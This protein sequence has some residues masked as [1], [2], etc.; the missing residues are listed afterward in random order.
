VDTSPTRGSATVRIDA[1]AETAFAHLTDL[2]KLPELSPENARCEFREPSNR[3]EVGARFRRHNK[4]LDHEW[5]ADCVITESFDA[6]LLE[7]PEIYPGR[8]EGRR[9][10]LQQGC[11]TT[12]ADLK[13]ALE[14]R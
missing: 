5:H 11:V 6:P 1:P 4:T 7:H 13:A 14:H 8:I 2:T 9:D 10:Q 3:L 12:L